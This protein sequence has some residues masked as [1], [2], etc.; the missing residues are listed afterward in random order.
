VAVDAPA[1]LRTQEL[2]DEIADEQAAT[3]AQVALAWLLRR[4][5]RSLPI[6]G[7]STDARLEENV[8]AALI[9]LTDDQ[10]RQLS[11]VI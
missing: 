11:D 6:P 9:E 4:S 10:V 7:T 1:A 8:R 2:I 5:T 3:P